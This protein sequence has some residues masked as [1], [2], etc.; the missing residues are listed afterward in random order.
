MY[1]DGYSKVTSSP[2]DTSK[3]GGL[4]IIMKY[5]RTVSLTEC[6]VN[7]KKKKMVYYIMTGLL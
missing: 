5:L 3:D 6:W 7:F 1:F 2:Q 4:Q